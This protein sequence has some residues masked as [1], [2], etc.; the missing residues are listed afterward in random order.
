MGW[1]PDENAGGLDV[2]C[3]RN[4]EMSD[5]PLQIVVDTN[6][7]VSAFRSQ[8]GASFALLKQLGNP[9]WQMNISTALILEYESVLKRQMVE[10]GIAVSV[11]DDVLNVI[12]AAS[13]ERGIFF[14]W[15]PMLADPG[16]DFLLELAV[17]SGADFIVTYNLRHF[18]GIEY[19]GVTAIKPMDF[20]RLLEKMP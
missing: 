5:R 6:I 9:R 11:A 18:I 15:R 10:Q 2:L 20:L 17:A 19:F 16:D 14:N 7:I 4:F 1:K 8:K 12:T 13:R 3:V